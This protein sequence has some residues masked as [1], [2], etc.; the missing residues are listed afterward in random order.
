MTDLQ[1]RENAGD[2]G[3]ADGRSTGDGGESE[4]P[5]T[6]ETKAGLLIERLKA[7]FAQSNG[8]SAGLEELKR[9]KKEGAAPTVLKTFL[10]L[11]ACRQV[12]YTMASEKEARLKE[13][14]ES[15]PVEPV[16]PFVPINN[17]KQSLPCSSIWDKLQG[18]D[19][20]RFCN[21]CSLQVYDF[22]KVELPEAEE[23][24]FQKEGKRQFVLF[25]R[26]DGKFLTAN[27]PVAVKNR[28]MMI[29]G[30][31]VGIVVIGGLIV[32]MALNPPPKPAANPQPVTS[33]VSGSDNSAENEKPAAKAPE[34]SSASTSP[35][36]EPQETFS[37]RLMRSRG[38]AV[39]V[40]NAPPVESQPAPDVGPVIQQQFVA[41]AGQVNQAQPYQSS[42]GA[43]GGAGQLGS[44]QVPA[45]QSPAASGNA[46]LQQQAPVESP[47]NTNQAPAEPS[48]DGPSG[49]QNPYVYQ[50]PN[51]NY[52]K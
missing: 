40:N 21:K 37:Q 35:A 51:S 18:T 13:E 14:L 17:Y 29:T 24:I 42:A 39:P 27:C 20:V 19:R 12:A 32:L 44:P 49:Q 1:P 46:Q 30:I 38:Y 47:Q 2:S 3:T 31:A 16:K 33:G 15:R 28:Y 7:E 25:K 5:V 34:S 11:D 48:A 10:D 9:L 26:P 36:A 41:P 45:V 52:Y 8:P 6:E 23:I 22:S 50:A 4:G 43:A